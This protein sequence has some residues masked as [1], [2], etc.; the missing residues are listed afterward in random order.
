MRWFSLNREKA[1]AA[2][3]SDGSNGY[4]SERQK[5]EVVQVPGR[6]QPP[7]IDEY[8]ST[9]VAIRDD[10]TYRWR[11]WLRRLRVEAKL[12][13]GRRA[14]GPHSF[15]STDFIV[16]NA[17]RGDPRRKNKDKK[18]GS[19]AVRRI[20]SRSDR[21]SWCDRCF[22]PEK[23]APNDLFWRRR[24]VQVG[25]ASPSIDAAPLMRAAFS[26]MRGGRCDSMRSDWSMTPLGLCLCC[27]C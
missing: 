2:S 3:P 21:K 14:T 23:L 8:A 5:Q 17:R 24:H 6:D 12:N 11:N 20:F 7:A 26:T 9:K 4:E 27:P 22:L 1:D 15:T 13:Q 18:V 19:K 10:E 16:A 25:G